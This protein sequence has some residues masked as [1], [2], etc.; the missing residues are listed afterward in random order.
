MRKAEPRILNNQSIYEGLNAAFTG[1]NIG[2]YSNNI[3][4]IW[5]ND[6]FINGTDEEKEHATN[7]VKRLC[8]QNN[9]VI[10]Y[11]KTLYK[12]EFPETIGEEIKEFTNQK[13]PAFFEY[14]KDKEKSQVNDRND[15]FVNKL[16]SRIPNK[17]IN[18]RGMK[19]GELK[20]KDMM[21]NP[22]IV[23]SKEVSDLY[24]ELNK[25]YRYMVNM[26]D[27]YID[28]LHYVACSIR[29]QF[30]ELGYS[31]EMIAD[32]LIQYLYGGEKRAK[33]LFWFCY[34]QYVVNNLE[35]NIKVRKTKLI[36][37][38]DCSEWFEVDIKDTK[39]CRCKDCQL[40]EKRRLDRE[41]R[42]KKRMSI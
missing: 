4:K 21:K 13:L 3:S 34:G 22:D 15:S 23:C 17:S 41:Y 11:A 24:D 27:E 38:I 26:K 32:M 10:D 14:A 8:C 36:Q 9:F 1:G 31:E 6:V 7:C 18:T 37:C 28:N 2:I 30:A 5:N 35:N 12:P 39:A 40:E 33:Q 19:L 20:Y 29:D 16:Y 42:R 25:K